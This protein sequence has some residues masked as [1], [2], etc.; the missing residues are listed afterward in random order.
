MHWGRGKPVADH[1]IYGRL[2]LFGDLR[3]TAGAEPHGPPVE[4][5]SEPLQL[6]LGYLALH[7]QRPI[8]RPQLAFLL[9]PESSEQT[10]L[11]NLRQQLHRLRQH[12]A[13]LQLPD[14]VLQ[15]Q[16]GQ[17]IFEPQGKLWID[18]LAFEK[19]VTA[20][21]H[22]KALAVY[23]APLLTQ[24]QNIA[25][26]KPWRE[27]FHTRY[28]QLLRDQIALK[29]QQQQPTQAL[30]YAERLLEASPL[31]ESSHR[32]YMETL[33]ASGR[34]VD[35]LQ[36]FEKLKVMLHEQLNVQPMAE[37]L[38]LYERIKQG[39]LPLPQPTRPVTK[40][41]AQ[42][43]TNQ[44]P[45][46]L[47]GRDKE[48][49]ALNEGL[50]QTG[51]N[52]GRMVVISG[53]NGLGRTYLLKQWLAAYRPQVD[54][55]A[56]VC[57]PQTPPFQPLVDAF[58]TDPNRLQ[59]PDTFPHQAA[60][61]T[62]QQQPQQDVL[63]PTQWQQLLLVINKPTIVALYNI[64]QAAEAL[65]ELVA[66]VAHRLQQRPLYLLATCQPAALT[67]TAQRHVKMLQRHQALHWLELVPLTAIETKQLATQLLPSP[68][69]EAYLTALWAATQ[70][71]PFFADAFLGAT[72]APVDGR[73]QL[74]PPPP[75]VWQTI[76]QSWAALPTAAQHILIHACSEAHS[77]AKPF[78]YE[79]V[80]QW[81]PHQPE[82]TRLQALEATIQQGFLQTES[83]WGYAF[84]HPQMA[85]FV[86]RYVDGRLINH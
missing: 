1:Q 45:S 9:W 73:Y 14:S 64:H 75:L 18:T 47:I 12:L 67:E 62:Q 69:D 26:L 70:G 35:A 31:R 24:Y 58:A 27:Q 11:R 25:W 84:A 33:Y 66:F 85:H 83:T 16:T 50:R 15:T 34:R 52:H 30:P 54:I 4:L 61:T 79:Q 86:R 82:E 65:W 63:S 6:L 78:A 8:N 59:L 7:A 68:P 32:I 5:N 17:L 41:L 57:Q 39:S 48:W 37:S 13:E 43:Q 40:P 72:A 49:A 44:P 80:V 28:L 29:I 10:A 2:K 76:A 22:Q 46:H 55:F 20:H 56:A 71:V 3:L 42:V 51:Q 81:L 21:Q 77:S 36:Q 23:T 53:A 19:N 38:L 74:P 60:W